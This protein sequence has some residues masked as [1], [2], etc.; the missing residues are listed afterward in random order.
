MCRFRSAT[1]SPGRLA[2]AQ[3]CRSI[4]PAMSMQSF[5]PLIDGL[6]DNIGEPS[7]IDAL[8][9][10]VA[11][12]VLRTFSTA[13]PDPAIMTY[14]CHSKLGRTINEV[15]DLALHSVSSRSAQRASPADR[16]FLQSDLAYGPPQQDHVPTMPRRA[17]PR[18]AKS[19]RM[20]RRPRAIRPQR[21]A[22]HPQRRSIRSR[23]RSP[24]G[25]GGSSRRSQ[26]SARVAA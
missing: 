13:T 26:R 9:S 12:L 2:Q 19:T 15:A 5:V 17:A 23:H 22:S 10:S 11:K 25:S 8:L 14:V 6:H 24:A 16:R 18:E 1:A 4:G 3:L 20:R 21:A 7:S